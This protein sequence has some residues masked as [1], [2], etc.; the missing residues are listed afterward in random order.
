MQLVPGWECGVAVLA[1]G[2]SVGIC[3]R[4]QAVL[5]DGELPLR[6]AVWAVE[7]LGYCFVNSWKYICVC[8]AAGVFPAL[9]CELP[10]YV[11]GRLYGHVRG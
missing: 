5:H 7:W 8:A 6:D 2:A 4:Y 1:G 9:S 10:C 11:C 3:G